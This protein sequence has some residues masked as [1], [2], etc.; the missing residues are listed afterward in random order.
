MP[1]QENSVVS[2][3]DPTQLYFK[4]MKQYKMITKINRATWKKNCELSYE[5]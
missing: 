3:S 4:R 5:K 1:P 2:I